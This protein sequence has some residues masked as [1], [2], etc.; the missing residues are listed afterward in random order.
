MKSKL[1]L[2]I[3]INF[4][5]YD[6]DVIIFVLKIWARTQISL[7]IQTMANVTLAMSP[8]NT[9]QCFISEQIAALNNSESPPLITHS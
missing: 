3:D 4:K 8:S 7:N 6:T 1:T 2:Y 5:L 9:Q